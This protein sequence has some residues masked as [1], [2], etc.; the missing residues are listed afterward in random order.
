[1]PAWFAARVDLQSAFCSRISQIWPWRMCHS[2]IFHWYVSYHTSKRKETKLWELEVLFV[3]IKVQFSISLWLGICAFPMSWVSLKL[4]ESESRWGLKPCELFHRNRPGCFGGL[5]QTPCLPATLS[6][7]G[8]QEPCRLALGWE[9]LVTA[10]LLQRPCQPGW[11][12]TPRRT[13][14]WGVTV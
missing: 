6:C 2:H 5:G 12:R 14:Q 7:G 8:W 3:H 1:M 4:R 10:D 11:P 13:C 9:E